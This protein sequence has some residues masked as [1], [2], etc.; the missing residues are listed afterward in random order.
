[1]KILKLSLLVSLFVNIAIGQNIAFEEILGTPF[2]GARNGSSAFADVNGDGSQDLLITGLDTL[3]P[4]TRLTK[5]YINDGAGNYTEDTG[6]NF[7]AVY[8]SSIAFADVDNNGSQDV[9]ITGAN[10]SNQSIAKLYIN[11]GTGNFTLATGTPFSGVRTGSIAFADVDNN[12]FQ[13]VLITGMGTIGL[14]SKLYTNDGTTF[15]LVTGTPFVGVWNSSIAFAD[16]DN[17]GYQD[18]LITGN[19]NWA[20]PPI[21]NSKLYLNNGNSTFS[22]VTNTPFE[23]VYMGS[24]AFADVDNNGSQDVLI[25]GNNGSNMPALSFAKLYSND[26]TGTF[27]AVAGTLDG[28]WFGSVDFADVDNDLDQDVLITGHGQS[29]PVAKLYA[30]DGTG[31]FT[32]VTGM[33]FDAVDYSSMA[34]VDIDNDQDQDVLITGH[35][36]GN[37]PTS[38]ISKLYRNITCS[39]GSTVTHSSCGSYTWIDGNTYTASNNTATHTLINA[40]GCDSVITL[41]L[42]VL[43][44]STGTDTQSACGTYTWIDGNTYVASNNTATHT[45][46]NAAGCD[47]VITLDLTVLTSS[48]GTDTQSACGTYTW[49]DGNTYV[50]SNNTATHTLTNAAGCDSVITLDLTI[51]ILNS[52]VTQTGL[53]LTAEQD[54]ATYQWLDCNNAYAMISGATNQEYTPGTSGTYAVAIT[55]G[56][57]TDTSNCITLAEV[58]TPEENIAYLPN[59]FSINSSNSENK[60]LYV[61]GRG[62]QSLELMIYDRWGEIV[63]VTTDANSKPRSS[64]GLCCAYGEGWDGT[65]MNTG[66]PLN[67]AV[68]AY[69][70]NI[71][72]S[73]G[74]EYYE[75]GNITLL[76]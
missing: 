12:G 29:G 3:L 46:T 50:A 4:S 52:S 60:R 66:K 62:I 40:A 51:N 19:S 70:L 64:D 15:Q 23:P 25:T 28:G 72:F 56:S 43:T 31:S 33:P 59:V 67:T 55:L 61:F 14:I 58:I 63:Y 36:V 20:V 8:M 6:A 22:E 73:N 34:F 16:V 48:T 47:S 2:E 35:D 76:K 41:D 44:S 1:M 49:I 54:G 17:N 26:G 7:D 71:T 32:E 9:L 45:L 38:G 57:C 11:D 13:D 37:G 75:K 10:P 42:T 68:F 30:N 27:T 24:V 39:N 21:K 65:Y 74:E 5:L 18:V 53:S 69:K